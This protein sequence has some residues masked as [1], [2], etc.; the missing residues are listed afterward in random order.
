MPK[1][2]ALRPWLFDLSRLPD[3]ILIQCRPLCRFVICAALGL[4]LI[5]RAGDWMA[6]EFAEC[7]P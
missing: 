3:N 4:V 5:P 6:R 7:R 1:I 2:S